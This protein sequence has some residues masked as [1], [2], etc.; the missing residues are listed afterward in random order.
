[1]SPVIPADAGISVREGDGTAALTLLREIPAFAGMTK[2]GGD[3]LREIPAF[4]GMTKGVSP[5]LRVS[6]RT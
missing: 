1:V 4:A 2:I 3:V 5:R 6:A